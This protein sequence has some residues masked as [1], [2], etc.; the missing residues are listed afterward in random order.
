L[1]DYIVRVDDSLETWFIREI[2]PYEG[3]LTR[4]LS[5]RR[6]R[7]HEV[8]DMRNDVYIR[9]LESARK[10]RPATPRAF[11]FVTARNLLVDRIRHERVVPI[12][13]IEDV[14]LA[15]LLIDELSAEHQ[16][17]GRQRLQQLAR[18]FD[19]LPQ[20]CREVLWMRRIEGLPQKT[21]AARLGLADA[22]VEKHLYRALRALTESFHGAKRIE[23]EPADARTTDNRLHHGD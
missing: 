15:D 18:M 7:A 3:A 4:Y 21:V 1:D 8:E 9:V 2:L 22:T 17:S 10:V 6:V 19:R 12:E 5:Q 14:E 11:L 20:R 23:E 13:Q 16:A